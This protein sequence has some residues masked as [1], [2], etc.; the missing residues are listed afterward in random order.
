[1]IIVNAI[2]LPIPTTVLTYRSN[3]RDSDGETVF[4]RGYK[5]SYASYH[6]VQ[7]TLQG[8]IYSLQLKLEFA[9]LS[10]LVS[11]IHGGTVDARLADTVRLSPLPYAGR[12]R[13]GRHS[14]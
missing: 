12:R 8:A 3:T 14:V 10:R 11:V 6:A 1:M 4:I 7:I 9:V 5:Q 13:D 2:I